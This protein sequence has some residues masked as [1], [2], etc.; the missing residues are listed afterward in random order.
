MG[1][2]C[3]KLLAA[4]AKGAR[5][6]WPQAISVGFLTL[7]TLREVMRTFAGTTEVDEAELDGLAV[8]VASFLQLLAEV[9]PE[10]N[11]RTSHSDRDKTLAAAAVMMHGY[12]AL[13]RDFNLDV[14]NLGSEQAR[15][16]WR[17]KLGRLSPKVTYRRGKWSGDFLSKDNPL[18][19]RLRICHGRVA[20]AANGL[21][22]GRREA[23]AMPPVKRLRQGDVL[24]REARYGLFELRRNGSMFASV[25]RRPSTRDLRS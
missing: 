24:P 22:T 10:L 5:I 6:P 17:T 12:A 14:G 25:G 9:R 20:R 7:S 13:M 18:W 11:V 23:G 3:A 4:T 1:G 16:A 2:P 15:K 21:G 19:E 8:I